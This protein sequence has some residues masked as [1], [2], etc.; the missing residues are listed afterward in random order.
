MTKPRLPYEGRVRI[1]KLYGTAPPAGVHYST[2]KHPGVDFVGVDNKSVV[3]VMEGKVTRVGYDPK[4]WGKY[5]TVQQTDNIFA[6]YCHLSSQA[7]TIGQWVLIGQ[8][9]GIEGSTGQVT[10]KHLHFE[11]RR[12]YTDKYSTINPT[13]YLGIKNV[14]GEVEEDLAEII[15]VKVKYPDGKVSNVKGIMQDG[16]NYV[17]IRQVLETLGYTVGWANNTVIINK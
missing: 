7:V 1:T 11:L 17:S 14:V 3:A 8:K 12:S 9:I 15:K 6:I 13:E 16:T 5:V 2:G 4:G 10:G